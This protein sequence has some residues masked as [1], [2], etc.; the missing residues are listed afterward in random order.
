MQEDPPFSKS[1]LRTINDDD[2]NNTKT[3]IRYILNNEPHE[4]FFVWESKSFN[5]EKEFG[6]LYIPKTHKL[7]VGGG[8]YVIVVDLKLKQMVFAKTDFDLFWSFE[9]Y[10][11][12]VIE[13]GETECCLYNLQG[14]PLARCPVDPPYTINKTNEA[15]IFT[16][17]VYGVTKLDLKN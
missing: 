13:Y 3:S 8:P 14:K 9:E 11:N 17:P 2:N 7:F 15:I 1:S 10:S 16:S 12:H 4:I 6:L 5:F